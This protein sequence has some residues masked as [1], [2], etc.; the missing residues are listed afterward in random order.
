MKRLR[1]AAVILSACL[2]FGVRSAQA[3]VCRPAAGPCD[4]AETWTTVAANLGQALYQPTDGVLYTNVAGDAV[5][6][7]GFKPNKTIVVT[8][9]G[10]FFNGTK[11][12]YLFDRTNGAV[13]ASASVTSANN[14][15]YTPIQPVTLLLNNPYSVAVYS[16]G[17]GAYRAS[18]SSMPSTLADATIEGT[19][20]RNGNTGEP[21]AS[22]GLIT[23]TNYGM[24]DIKYLVSNPLYQPTDGTLYT[25]VSGDFIAGYGFTP[26]KN[27][28]VTSLGGLWNGTK[29]VYLFNRTTGAVLA[30]ASVTSANSWIYSGI[31]PVTLTAGTPYTVA[32]YSAGAGAYR[33]GLSSMPSSRA[34]ATID[35]TC[36]RPGNSGEPCAASGLLAGNNYGMA[37]IKYAPTG[38]ATFCPVDSF[39]PASSICRPAASICDLAESCTGSSAACPADL[40]APASPSCTGS[41]PNPIP[42]PPQDPVALSGGGAMASLKRSQTADPETPAPVSRVAPVWVTYSFFFS[43]LDSLDRAA[44]EEEAS[45]NLQVA[46]DWRKHEQLAADLDARQGALL[47][48]VAAECLQAVAAKDEEIQKGLQAFR[49]EHPDG[50]FVTAQLPPKLKAL[51]QQRIDIIERQIRRLQ[52]LLGDEGFHKL[53]SYIRA[54]F[55]P[56]V[57]EPAQDA[58]NGGVQ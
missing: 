34:D 29:T 36:Y 12:V 25:D 9:L 24:V 52:S 10:G 5:A 20:Y 28:T 16:A 2:A 7:Y 48:Q 17:A 1:V 37:D 54:N 22:S 55:V 35:G 13:L 3:Q 58:A 4:I 47:K 56:V 18:M 57:V 53:D 14:W 27:L 21:C 41:S 30:S 50:A 39:L 38:T 11:T 31:T 49:D 45:G 40:F 15:A 32:M 51:W 6:G 42:I 44:A 46:S 19:C 23:G 33:G 8:A 26:N 43:H